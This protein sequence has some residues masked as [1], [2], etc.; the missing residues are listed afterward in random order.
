MVPALLGVVM[1]QARTAPAPPT[2][3]K[4]KP[5]P[6]VQ[7]PVRQSSFQLGAPLPG[8]PSVVLDTK[9]NG[10][11]LAQQ[12]ARARNL[13]GR[14]LWVDGT[15]NLERVGSEEKIVNLVRRVKN[16]GFNTI[17]FDVKPIVGFTLYPSQLTEKIT[18]WR[19][20]KLDKSFDPL[21][22][23]VRE[24][25]RHNIPLYLSLNAFSEGHRM[26]RQGWGY[27]HPQFQTVQ[28]DPIPTLRS[29]RD[30]ESWIEYQVNPARNEIRPGTIAA[31]TSR[32]PFAI[33]DQSDAVVV[34]RDG[35]VRGRRDVNGLPTVPRGGSMLVAL[36][37]K[38][39][40][41]L[42]DHAYI[43]DRLRFDLV[44]RFRPISENQTQWPLMMNP[45]QPEVQQRALSFIEELL[46][47]Y[48]VQGIVFDDRLRYGGLNADFS[49]YTRAQFEKFVGRPV[50]WPDDVFRF[51]T[52]PGLEEGLRPGK[53][54]DVWLTWRAQTLTNWV[55]DARNLIDRL[56][57]GTQFGIYAG[58]WYGEY[59]KFG[60]NFASPNFQAGF[61]F[62]TP[63]Y[64]QTG[65]AH[66]LDFLITGCYYPVA[67]ITEAMER[68]LPTGRT[69][70]AAGQLSN[71]VARDKT[72]TYAG[73]MLNDYKDQPR[74]FERALQA[75]TASTQG[76][77]VFDLSHDIDTFWPS[78]ERAFR[79]PR[80]SP[81]SVPGLLDDVRKR[82]KALDAMGT[83][84]GATPIR[85]GA[86]GTG[87]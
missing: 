66:T 18:E 31:Y 30:A 6:H 76:V 56:K 62:M 11:G 78:L 38:S 86:A 43:G 51:T 83:K 16:V 75:A 19:G 59:T 71:R 64:Q 63:E 12:T 79:Q 77:M 9:N 65:F 28:Y 23:M 69:V 70:E 4:P 47:N 82:R 24:C 26:T 37:R 13:Q 50:Q 15:A 61:A 5:I 67:T 10:W 32:P 80:V 2:P 7:V 17:I 39:M 84:D 81:N 21:A 3:P 73:I 29:G 46:T 33:P 20:Q 8:L 25:K 74:Q 41:F 40:D 68:G 45:H 72:W 1:G 53:Y 27:Q 87:H 14:I 58:S 54:Y 44:P 34:D 48:D 36:D 60:A 85:E 35:I 55:I 52:S 22:V 42:L 49:E 57:P